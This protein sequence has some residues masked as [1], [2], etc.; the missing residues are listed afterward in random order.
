[1]TD[2][3]GSAINLNEGELNDLGFDT[4]VSV[5][6]DLAD[7][8]AP[9]LERLEFGVPVYETPRSRSSILTLEAS[10]DVSGVQSRVVMEFLSPTG[11]S[12]QK[13]VSLDEETNTATGVFSFP[14]YAANGEYRVNTIRLYDNAGNSSFSR[15]VFDRKPELPLW[16]SLEH[17]AADNQLPTLDCPCKLTAVFD[18]CAN[19]PFVKVAGLR[20]RR[21]FRR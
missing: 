18:P 13:W 3:L 19:R 1:M 9:Q 11:K 12:L 21:S 6:N 15:A 17:D 8:I 5:R 20:N 7:V 16:C 4:Q 14:L 2:D 10:D